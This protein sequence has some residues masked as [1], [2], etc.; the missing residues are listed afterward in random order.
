M[1]DT[2]DAQVKARLRQ[3]ILTRSAG[4]WTEHEQLLAEAAYLAGLQVVRD[5]QAAEMQALKNEWD[6][7]ERDKAELKAHRDRLE[8]AWDRASDDALECKAKLTEAEAQR[9]RLREYVK[10]KPDCHLEICE[11]THMTP[12]PFLIPGT[13]SAHAC[14]C[15]LAALLADTETP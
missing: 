10:H 6:A 2:L 15:G 7:Q 9:A 13:A 8:I 12:H 11:G 14:T 1:T 3:L 4:A 5:A